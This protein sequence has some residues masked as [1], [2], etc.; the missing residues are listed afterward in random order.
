ML[1]SLWTQFSPHLLT[2]LSYEDDRCVFQCSSQATDGAN[3]LTGNVSFQTLISDLEKAHGEKV[4]FYFPNNVFPYEEKEENSRY[5]LP[6]EDTVGFIPIHLFSRRF[7]PKS[8][9][10]SAFNNEY[11][12]QKVQD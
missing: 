9:T 5:A 3:L 6:P 1:S 8:L 10:V 7:G 2:S 11:T 12:P 4:N